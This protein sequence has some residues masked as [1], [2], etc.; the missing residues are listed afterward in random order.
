MTRAEGQKGRENNDDDICFPLLPSIFDMFITEKLNWQVKTS[1]W[2]SLILS[3]AGRF[4]E[5]AFDYEYGLSS[6]VCTIIR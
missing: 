5:L 4:D 2:I 1:Q 6:R 3:P